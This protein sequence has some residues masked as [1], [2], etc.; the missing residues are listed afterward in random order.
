MSP[1]S[2]KLSTLFSKLTS[3]GKKKQTTISQDDELLL[4]TLFSRRVLTIFSHQHLLTFIPKVTSASSLP[5][6]E[7]QSNQSTGNGERDFGENDEKVIAHARKMGK[8]YERMNGRVYDA[9]KLERCLAEVVGV[10]KEFVGAY[11]R[12]KRDGALGGTG[13]DGAQWNEE[14][15]GEV[16]GVEGALADILVN[17]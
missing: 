10:K 3:A 2:C 6:I 12:W 13:F 16:G 17:F 5:V 15:V 7:C 8:D 1:V 11:V 4:S 14:W 9:G